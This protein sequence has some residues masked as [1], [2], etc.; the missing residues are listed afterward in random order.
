MIIALYIK[1]FSY[2]KTKTVKYKVKDAKEVKIT[3]G[4][5]K[6]FITCCNKF[7]NTI[8]FR[9]K[10]LIPEKDLIISIINEKEFYKTN[11]CRAKEYN[12]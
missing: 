8:N 10:P 12:K 3:G 9:G 6:F 7:N 4:C 2:L 5:N 1:D 11:I